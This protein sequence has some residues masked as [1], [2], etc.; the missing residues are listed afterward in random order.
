MED[1][2]QIEYLAQAYVFVSEEVFSLNSSAHHE[3]PK[4]KPLNSSLMNRK[5]PNT[6]SSNL[7]HVMLFS[8]DKNCENAPVFIVAK[9]KNSSDF[10]TNNGH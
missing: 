2:T 9:Q 10:T 6:F 7:Y 4:R 1:E 5:K 8:P 3:L